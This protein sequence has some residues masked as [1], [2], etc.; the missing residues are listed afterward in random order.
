MVDG[1]PDGM[2]LVRDGDKAIISPLIQ[3]TENLTQRLKG[4]GNSLVPQLAAIFIRS[5]M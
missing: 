2:G 4:Y 5:T 3:E 1:F